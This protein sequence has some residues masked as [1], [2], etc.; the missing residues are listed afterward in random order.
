MPGEVKMKPQKM[1]RRFLRFYPLVFQRFYFPKEDKRED[2][3]NKAVE[4]VKEKYRDKEI[5]GFPCKRVRCIYN[6]AY[7]I[8]SKFDKESDEYLY[9][10]ECVCDLTKLTLNKD[11]SCGSFLTRGDGHYIYDTFCQIY[12]E[13]EEIR[14]PAYYVDSSRRRFSTRDEKLDT[15]KYVNVTILEI[16]ENFCLVQFKRGKRVAVTSIRLAE[17]L[18]DEL[19]R[20]YQSIIADDASYD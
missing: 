10:G 12:H 5:G 16:F 17:I 19:R 4:R 9:E 6:S 7:I 1:K 18:F 11:G 14:V 13:G 8:K 3:E 20:R 15:P 2:E